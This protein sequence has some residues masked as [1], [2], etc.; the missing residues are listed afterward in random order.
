VPA[1]KSRDQKEMRLPAAS[2]GVRALA[3]GPQRG[4]L[5]PGRP[6]GTVEYVS[7]AR[8]CASS[9][10]ES[11]PF[12]QGRNGAARRGAATEVPSRVP[13]AGM[14]AAPMRV[15]WWSSWLLAQANENTG[16]ESRSCA[17]PQ[18]SGAPVAA[19]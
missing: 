10:S 4:T 2:T 5:G 13:D 14:A 17:P 16:A 8:N 11:V 6:A 18:P 12:L 19:R 7:G 9:N 1:S 3:F 15:V